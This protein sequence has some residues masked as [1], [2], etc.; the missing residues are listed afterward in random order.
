MNWKIL[1]NRQRQEPLSW[2]QL[3]QGERYCS[4]IQQYLTNHFAQVAGEYC[5]KIGALSAEVAYYPC[6]QQIIVSEKI[7]QNLTALSQCPHIDLVQAKTI[8][9]PFVENCFSAC[10][11]SHSLHFTADPHQTLREITRVLNQEGMLFISLFNPLNLFTFKQLLPFHV[12][13]LSFTPCFAT[14]V[15]DWLASLNV[16][17]L[18]LQKLSLQ[19]KPHYFSEII[20]IVAQKRTVPMTLQPHRTSFP[21]V[22]NPTN[23]FRQSVK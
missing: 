20:L 12:N 2:Q 14:Q 5:L 15:I 18:K 8:A 23:A 16:D 1:H 21:P 22:L 7:P 13:K 4:V 11:L 9:L 6:D 19:G 10:L 3:P 17:L